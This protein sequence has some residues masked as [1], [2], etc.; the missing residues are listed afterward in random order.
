MAYV[1]I[2]LSKNYRKTYVGSTND[3]MRRLTEL[4]SGKCN[5]TSKFKPWEIFHQ[6]KYPSIKEARKREKYLKTCA[7]RKF[8][9]KLFI[10]R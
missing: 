8:I 4:N 1:Y 10:P 5:F 9:S 3:L 6:E 2:L 7:G